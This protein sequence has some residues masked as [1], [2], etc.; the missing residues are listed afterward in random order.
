MP[1]NFVNAPAMFIAG[2]SG[3]AA[4]GSRRSSDKHASVLDHI[5]LDLDILDTSSPPDVDE[6]LE[7][8]DDG[9]DD[10]LRPAL[11][12]DRDHRRQAMG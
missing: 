7:N 3:C 11:N 9:A 2:W 6:T 1:L 12:L 5:P 8:F 10:F 4:L